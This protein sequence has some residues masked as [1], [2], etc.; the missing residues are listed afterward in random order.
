[1]S[2]NRHDVGIFA[3]AYPGINYSKSWYFSLSF[4]NVTAREDAMRL[5]RLCAFALVLTGI[6]AMPASASSGSFFTALDLGE[7]CVN[8]KKSSGYGLCL[9]YIGGVTDAV[10]SI[11]KGQGRQKICL[12]DG[13]K[14]S[15]LA[16]GFL[17]FF[18]ANPDVLDDDAEDAVIE[19]L[20]NKYPC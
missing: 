17:Q 4:K 5:V 16:E 9:G 6:N 8:D 13:I 15:Q 10:L 1:M 2:S 19:M 7:A 3:T 14:L 20:G 12:P 18:E 11:D